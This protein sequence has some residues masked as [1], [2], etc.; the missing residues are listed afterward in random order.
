MLFQSPY[1]ETKNLH[2]VLIRPKMFALFSTL[3]IAAAL[4][5][6]SSPPS[7]PIKRAIC[8]VTSHDDP[9][10]DDAPLIADALRSCGSTGTVHFPANQ[11]FTLRSPLDLLPCRACGIQIDGIVNISPD[12]DYWEKQR[13]ALLL[14]NASNVVISSSEG[15]VGVIDAQGFG[16]AGEQEKRERV[17]RLFEIGEGSS[18][19]HVRGLKI[20]NAPGPVFWVGGGSEAVRLYGVDVGG[21]NDTEGDI[22]AGIG[23]EVQGARH[24]YVWD[25]KIR[26]REA[27]VKLAPDSANVQIEEVACTASGDGGMGGGRVPSG[28]EIGVGTREVVGWVRNV[29][30]KKMRA[31]GRM[32]VVAFVSRDEEES[33]QGYL[34]IANATF[35]DVKI[36][37]KAKRPFVLEQ[38][39]SRVNATGVRFNGFAGCI[40]DRKWAECAIPEDLCDFEFEDWNVRDWC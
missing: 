4:A 27:C 33:G 21:N 23:V 34:E 10:T 39:T 18:Q 30:V 28:V 2:E 5:T 35:T 16:W 37:G 3:T 8:T 29:L 1:L 11:T 9:L 14:N 36:E 40:E 15:N 7:Q 6:A 19:I 24:V 32:N 13:A 20:R 17:P 12:W 22:A 26:A 31:I 38:G 25:G